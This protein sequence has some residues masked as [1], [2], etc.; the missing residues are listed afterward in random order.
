MPFISRRALPPRL[1]DIKKE[2]E[3]YARQFGLDFF[4][5]IFEVL[6]YEEINMVAA[7]GGFPNRY[8][9]WRFGMEYDHLQKSYTYGLHK[10]YEMVINN[11]PC[12]A[13]LLESNSDM[14][15]K[16]VMAHVFGH[17]D[18]FKNNL[19]FEPTNRKMMDEMANH[20]IRIRKYIDRHGQD[21]V[22]R[23]VDVCLS[24]ENLID[25]FKQYIKRRDDAFS[26]EKDAE[27]LKAI[28]R[29]KYGREY[30]ENFINPDEFIEAQKQ[31]LLKRD[32]QQQ[33]KFPRHPERDVLKFLMEHAQLSFWQRDIIDVVREEGYYFNPQGM[34]KIMNEGWAVYWHSKIMTTRALKD[35]ELIDYADHHSG[36]LFTPPGGF[37]PYK[38]G[39]ELFRNIE[40]R[41]NK[42]CFG[43]AYDECEDLRKKN[44]WDLRLM[45]GSEK[46]FEVRRM[47]ND[48]T[49][50]DEFLTPE[51][52]NEQKLFVYGFNPTHHRWE[53]FS[54][55]FKEVKDKLLL[56]LTNMGKPVILV[57]DANYKNRGELLLEHRLDAME[58]DQNYAHATLMNIFQVW[59]RPVHILTRYEDKRTILSYDGEK[60]FEEVLDK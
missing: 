51:F 48:I 47:H 36:T 23:F 43:K 25:P 26:K 42:G 30:M 4:D 3:A 56:M 38:I 46:I 34:T 31:K 19:W 8:P 10:I 35:S 58:L 11:N 29:L 24:L 16:L 49:F 33:Q 44:E 22:E 20:G 32:S 57:D 14:D 28:P 40:E 17:C 6:T 2:V 52:C 18:F 59:R 7:Y 5:T 45:L 12:F 50:I 9:H 37:N 27:P 13:Y 60:H 53:V 21:P 1:A 41:W 15:Q 55:K 39:V 54:R